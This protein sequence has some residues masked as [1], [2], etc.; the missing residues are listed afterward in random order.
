MAKEERELKCMHGECCNEFLYAVTPS[1]PI[2]NWDDLLKF[3][4]N[5]ERS[6]WQN[7]WIFR[8]HENST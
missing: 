2:T 5:C 6:S 4:E 7:R 1:K 8:A 3:Y